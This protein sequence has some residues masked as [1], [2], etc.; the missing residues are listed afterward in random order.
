MPTDTRQ[1]QGEPHRHAKGTQLG[2]PLGQWQGW[3]EVP[4][5]VLTRAGA[6]RPGTTGTGDSQH[7][8]SSL[9][10]GQASPARQSSDPRAPMQEALPEPRTASGV[11][12]RVTEG[13]V[14][15]PLR[16]V[17][18]RVQLARLR[19]RSRLG[20]H[21]A[22]TMSGIK[23]WDGGMWGRRLRGTHGWGIAAP[24]RSG[25]ASGFFLHRIRR[26]NGAGGVPSP[27][28][29]GGGSGVPCLQ[30]CRI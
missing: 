30:G 12:G 19:I 11:V 26:W 20:A 24:G 29:R 25:R 16:A 3:L 5:L 1:G 4:S 6:R 14:A 13:E 10:R 8:T 9:H 17:S 23:E 22:L 2:R 18:I 7:L 28:G 15:G 27:R 21:A